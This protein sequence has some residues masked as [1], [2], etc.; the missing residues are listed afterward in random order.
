MKSILRA[1]L[2]PMAL[3][4]TTIAP[5]QNVSINLLSQNAGLVTVG[6]N[7]FLEVTINNTDNSLSVPSYK[8]RPQISVPAAIVTI[9]SSGHILPPGWTIT[10]NSGS[11]VRLSN[12]T[13]NVPPSSARTILIALQGVTLGGPSTISGNLFFSNGVAPGSASGPALPG[14]LTADNTSTT[15]VEVN[16]TAPVRLTELGVILSDCRPAL[17]WITSSE[18]NSSHFEVERSLSGTAQ[19]ASIGSVAARGN[20]NN[21]VRYQFNDN[22]LPLSARQVFYRLRMIDRD[23]RYRYS[24]VLPVSLNCKAIGVSVFP[25]P[26]SEGRLQVSIS[27]TDGDVQAALRNLSGQLMTSRT[28]RAGTTSMDVSDLAAGVYVLDLRFRDGRSEKVRVVVAK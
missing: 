14:D 24:S 1:A 17:R 2:L 28:L 25:N 5:A 3:L 11:V 15:T 7:I 18:L 23:G 21:E 19:W 4:L 22:G 8:L 6:G 9:P 27:G 16:G 10:F 26:V 13:D 20:S 12:G